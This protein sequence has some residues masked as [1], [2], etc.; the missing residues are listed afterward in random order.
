MNLSTLLTKLSVGPL[1]DLSIG[2]S[3]AGHISAANQPK[4]TFAANEALRALYARFPLDERTAIIETSNGIYHYKL[5]PAFAESNVASLQPV[6]YIKDG[7]GPT[8]DG[9]VLMI[10]D[11]FDSGHCP[12]ALNDR[13]NPKS[14]HTKGNTG[15]VMDYPV[16]GVRYFIGYRK[17]HPELPVLLDEIETLTIDQIEII[18]PTQLEAALAHH[19]ASG[20]YAGMNMESSQAKTAY[21]LQRYEAECVFHENNNTFNGSVAESNMKF[22][23]GGW[24]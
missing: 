2:N 6:K 23:N 1:R 8:F 7:M 21:H 16:E 11:V 10:T 12:L 14:W 18:V 5:D 22:E 9:H 15:L 20:I 24:I 17:A 4:V 19:V 3:G 13:N